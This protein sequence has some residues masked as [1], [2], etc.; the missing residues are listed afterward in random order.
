[1]QLT[2]RALAASLCALSFS[3]PQLQAATSDKPVFDQT[4][5]VQVPS[6]SLPPSDLQSEEATRMLQMRSK[7]PHRDA[8]QEPDA[9][10]ARQQLAAMLAPQVEGMLKAYPVNVAEES[11]GGVPVRIVTPKGGKP[12]K[13]RVL[14]NLHGGAFNTCWES[15]SLIESAPIAAEGNYKVVSVNYRMAPE[16]KHPAAVEDV[17]SVYRELLKN[18][19][20]EHIGIYGCSAGGFLTSQTAAWL[21]QQNL[22]QPAA[23]GIFGAG[24]V[25]FMTGDSAWIAA[26]IDG[27]FPPPS[28][29]EKPQMDLTRGYFDGA[30]MEEPTVSPALHPET[31]KKFPPTM[32]ITGTRAMDMSPAIYTN[33]E[34]LKAGTDS[35]LV[36]GEGM[37]HCYIYQNYLPEARDTYGLI[38]NFFRKNLH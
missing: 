34:L 21:P 12:D 20:P 27:S 18:Y 26:S 11:I 35:T 10:K 28:T 3:I 15:C 8:V 30:D 25:R 5:T 36:V 17:T 16:A 19:K 22:P 9:I 33:T 14:I 38:V 37:G 6:F 31:L 1:M 23:I 2:R 24:S 4:G 29:K 7:M 32:I 13:D